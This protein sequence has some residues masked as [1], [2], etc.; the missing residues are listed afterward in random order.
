MKLEVWSRQLPYHDY[1]ASHEMWMISLTELPLYISRHN[2]IPCD[3]ILAG[4]E[5]NTQAHCTVLKHHGGAT[6]SYAVLPSP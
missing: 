1:T 2:K 4:I 3:R 6:F 5:A